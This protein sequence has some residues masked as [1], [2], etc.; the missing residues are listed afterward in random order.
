MHVWR[1]EGKERGLDPWYW[2]ELLDEAFRWSAWLKPDKVEDGHFLFRFGVLVFHIS[3]GEGITQT[4]QL[5]TNSGRIAA[6]LS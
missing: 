2:D 3:C 4:P 1:S 5:P 6:V